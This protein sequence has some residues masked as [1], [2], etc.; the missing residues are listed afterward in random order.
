[1]SSVYFNGKTWVY[2]FSVKDVDTG[3]FK[4]K[5]EVLGPK[6]LS[7][8]EISSIKREKDAFYRRKGV[9]EKISPS[10]FLSTAKQKYLEQKEIEVSQNRRSPNTLRTDKACLKLF[11]EYIFA[12]YGD[13]DVRKLTRRHIIRWEEQRYTETKSTSTVAVNMRTVK[14]FFSYLVKKE[15]I[16]VNPFKGLPTPRTNKRNVENLTDIFDVLY[17]FIQGEIN[18]RINGSERPSLPEPQTPSKDDEFEP[19]LDWFYNNK[20]FVH[21]L[22]LMLNTGMR[23][24]EVSILKWRRGKDDTGEGHSHSYSYISSDESDI[25]IYFKRR[26]RE[27]KIHMPVK[28]S[29]EFV[30]K[31][32]KNSDIY[33]FQNP[34]SAKPIT[35]S[36]VGKLFKKLMKNLQLNEDYTPHA[37]RHGYASFLS[38]EGIILSQLAMILGHTSEQVTEQYY[39]H[40]RLSDISAAMNVL[41]EVKGK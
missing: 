10:Y 33:V 32:G 12:H 24:G 18:H 28:R 38:K 3:L 40:S 2:Q 1:M 16:D 31:Q 6:P 39:L 8:S 22:W 20:W 21:Y 15:R 17:E 34:S 35:V 23:S 26:L 14:S 36:A 11:Y 25:T 41:H 5:Y 7:K 19:K 4:R 37:I 13:L 29:L 9:K 27:M 30:R